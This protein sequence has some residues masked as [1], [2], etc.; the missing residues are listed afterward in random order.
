MSN[1]KFAGLDKKYG[2]KT[3]SK[4]GKKEW[5]KQDWM[6]YK[7]GTINIAPVFR[8]LCYKAK[9]IYITQANKFLSFIKAPYI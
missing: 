5:H 3:W 4:Y 8:S 1:R 7:K 2:L 6:S 9:P